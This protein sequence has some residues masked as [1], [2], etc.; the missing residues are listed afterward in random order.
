VS[1]GWI[2][3]LALAVLLSLRSDRPEAASA[4]SRAAPPSSG[5]MLMVGEEL[6][7]KVKYLFLYLGQIKIRV[8]DRH[9]ENGRTVYGGTA[10]I[11]SRVPLIADLHVR[12]DSDIDEDVYSYG[13]TASDSSSHGVYI[14]NIRFDYDRNRMIV[15]RGQRTN[16]GYQIER[17]DT[18]PVNARCQD[19][20]S[21]FFYAREHVMD[22]KEH[23]VPTVID[24]EQ[25]STYINFHHKLDDVSIGAVDYDV[26]VVG[27]DGRADF[28]GIFG[29]TGGFEGWFSNDAARVPI[30]AYMNVLIGSVKIELES[31]N[32]PGWSPPKAGGAS[33]R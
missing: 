16:A 27:F 29:L 3:S 25:V 1:F 15:D 32:R 7:Y 6:T 9:V 21:L 33:G 28:V 14:R 13:W 22:R 4:A 11:D 12:F 19:G 2:A 24:T 18:I 31:W 20:L 30:L 23:T 10:L 26:D 8:N 17:A 5:G